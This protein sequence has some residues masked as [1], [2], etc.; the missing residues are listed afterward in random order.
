MDIPDDMPNEEIVVDYRGMTGLEILAD[1]GPQFGFTAFDQG[2]GTV[3]IVPTRDENAQNPDTRSHRPLQPN[4]GNG[5]DTQSLPR[6][7]GSP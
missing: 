4:V 3:I 6:G 5:V 1:M 7:N 2:G